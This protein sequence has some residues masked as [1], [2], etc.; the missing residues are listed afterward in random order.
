MCVFYKKFPTNCTHFRCEGLTFL[1]IFHIMCVVEI[2]SLHERRHGMYY[3]QSEDRI[4]LS[5][6]ELCALALRGGHLDN[7]VPPVSLYGRAREGSELHRK[8]QE[9]RGEGYHAEVALKNTCRL[10]DVTFFV[11]GRADG[12]IY[13]PGGGCVVEEIK[14]VAGM[15]RYVRSPRGADLAQLTCYGYFLCCAKGLSSV[16]LRL[17]YVGT[18]EGEEEGHVDALMT[19]E[20]LRDGYVSML[21]MILP[22]A[23]DLRER[24]TEVR[25]AAKDAVFPYPDMRAAQ[26]DM[27]KECWRDMRRGQTL[28]AQAPTGI[29][30]TMLAHMPEEDWENHLSSE[31]PQF[32]PNTITDKDAIFEELRYIRRRG[33]AISD[34]WD[35]DLLAKIQEMA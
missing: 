2:L 32:Q 3:C 5:V 35:K 10:G 19:A 27:I 34:T 25:A 12:I 29:G 18:G 33:F 26:A 31:R 21:G 30:K 14:S 23:R 4:E 15:D 11:S 17:T 20:A 6:R 16:T 1:K 7:R 13:D 24:E 8:M 28:F 22:R 9:S